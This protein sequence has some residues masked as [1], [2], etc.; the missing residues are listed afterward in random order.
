M[1]SRWKVYWFAPATAIGFT[2][3]S[4]LATIMCISGRGEKGRKPSASAGGRGG[5]RRPPRAGRERRGRPRQR[6][7]GSPLTEEGLLAQLLAQALHD[8]VA[9]GDVRDEVSWGPR[10]RPARPQVTP[11]RAGR[12]RPPA[13][14]QPGGSRPPRP[15]P[16]PARPRLLPVHYIQVEIVGPAVQ[17]AAA[18]GAQRRQVAVED[19]RPD[20][21][22][23]RHRCRPPPHACAAA[24]P[25]GRGGRQRHRPS[26]PRAA[27]PSAILRAGPGRGRSAA[28]DWL[29]PA[30][31][32]RPMAGA[33]PTRK[34]ES[35]QREA[36]T[37]HPQAVR[38][39]TGEQTHP[40]HPHPLP[41]EAARQGPARPGALAVPNSRCR[42]PSLKGRPPRPTARFGSGA[43]R[44]PA[45]FPACPARPR[46]AFEGG[47]EPSGEP[48]SGKGP[49]LEEGGKNPN[50]LVLTGLFSFKLPQ[51]TH[52]CP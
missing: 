36:V 15:R 49:A 29:P 18:L 37:G 24:R 50:P 34:K 11:G 9:E 4:G 25:A 31:G 13:G 6:V 39:G 27:P 19:G 23:R 46:W 38:P 32:P 8:G 21:A 2:H 52:C 20:P 5:G 22:P 7:P 47:T 41:A 42:G 35:A 10:E 30:Q 17:H 43:G 28:G 14:P 12:G 51:S 40:P 1:A 48:P 44:P 26:P 3:C 16:G 45:L 33:L